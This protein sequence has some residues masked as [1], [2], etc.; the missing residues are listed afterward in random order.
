MRPASF[1]LFLS[2]ATA[3]PS[4]PPGGSCSA[5]SLCIAAPV[6]SNAVLQRAPAKAAIT[7]SVPLGYHG[8]VSLELREE[9]G[10]FSYNSTVT[11]RPDGTWKAL[12][13][14]RGLPLATTR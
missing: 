8:T 2:S 7:G 5:T 13:P 14:P 3:Y 9:D 6:G 11:V 10:S 1:I 12:L 4:Y